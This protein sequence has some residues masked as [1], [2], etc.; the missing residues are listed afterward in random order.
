MTARRLARVSSSYLL[1]L[2]L[3]QNP[4]GEC[5]STLSQRV[6]FTQLAIAMDAITLDADTIDQFFNLQTWPTWT[7]DD[8]KME[9]NGQIIRGMYVPNF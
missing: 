3:Q 1:Q 8:A 6:S 9:R 2:S 5:Q 4:N 7:E